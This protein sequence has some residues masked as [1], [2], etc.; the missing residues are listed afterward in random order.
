VGPGGRRRRSAA[1]R[2]RRL[3]PARGTQ[4]SADH[5]RASRSSR[6]LGDRPRARRRRRW[7]GP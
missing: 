3:R 6:K 7:A 2:A 5:R 4:R 1:L